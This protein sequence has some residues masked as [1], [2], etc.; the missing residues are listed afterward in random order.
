[1][2]TRNHSLRVILFWYHVGVHGNPGERLTDLDLVTY[3]GEKADHAVDGGGQ[4]V[5]HL[6]RFDGDY[7]ASGVDFGTVVDAYRYHRAGHGAGQFGVAAVL[8]VWAHR[9]FP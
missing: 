4:R 6:H 9:G 5:L 3:C 2:W 8:V 1:R 7:H